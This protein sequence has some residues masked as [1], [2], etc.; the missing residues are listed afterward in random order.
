MC[1]IAE[2]AHSCIGSLYQFFPNKQSVAEALREEYTREV[3][4]SWISLERRAADLTTE[5]LVCRL[6]NLQLDIV[7]THPALLELLDVPPSSRTPARR[8]G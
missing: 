2:R 5:K 1:A 6:V 7:K 8:V 3:E 4:Q